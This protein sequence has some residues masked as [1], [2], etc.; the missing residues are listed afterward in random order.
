MHRLSKVGRTRLTASEHWAAIYIHSSH[1]EGGFSNFLS[2]LEVIGSTINQQEHGGC[3]RGPNS[4]T[5]LF[6]VSYSQSLLLYLSLGIKMD[7]LATHKRHCQ[8]SLLFF[9]LN[10]IEFEISMGFLGICQNY[11]I[12]QRITTMFHQ[13]IEIL[14]NLS[15]VRKRWWWLTAQETNAAVFIIWTCSISLNINGSRHSWKTPRN[16]T[17]VCSDGN[18][19]NLRGLLDANYFGT[20]GPPASPQPQHSLPTEHILLLPS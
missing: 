16:D 19:Q 5:H 13:E 20:N 14:F 4:R 7:Q 17:A 10:P 11:T 15:E 9:F 12:L 8:D 18:I 3:W 6:T 2:P 1:L